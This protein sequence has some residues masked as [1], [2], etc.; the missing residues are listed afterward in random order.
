MMVASSLPSRTGLP[1]SGGV[2]CDDALPGL[3]RVGRRQRRADAGQVGRDAGFHRVPAVELADEQQLRF[4]VHED[5]A[6]R[7]GRERGVQRHRHVAGHPDR[8]VA[9]QPVRAVLRQD[10][11]ARAR[12]EAQALQVRRH[13]AGFVHHLRPGVVAHRAAAE[14][15]GQQRLVRGG[16][17]P[18]VQALQGE[19]VGR[20][21]RVGRSASCG[22]SVGAA[23]RAPR[24]KR[25]VGHHAGPAK[26]GTTRCGAPASGGFVEPA[27]RRPVRRPR[28]RRCGCRRG[29]RSTRC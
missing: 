11:D 28:P 26:G 5:L 17:L 14:R 9:H 20:D 19:R 16:A 7:L 18:V 8:E 3:V 13:A 6:D 23:P 27:D 12:L 1:A 24:S 4:A 22:S 21:K 29:C 15:L 10:R 2:A 25:T